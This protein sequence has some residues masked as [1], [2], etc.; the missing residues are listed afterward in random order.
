M[1]GGK[2][3]KFSNFASPIYYLRSLIFY[4]LWF[5]VRSVETVFCVLNKGVHNIRRGGGQS[6]F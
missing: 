4:I 5:G 6:F 2:V 3:L 1:D